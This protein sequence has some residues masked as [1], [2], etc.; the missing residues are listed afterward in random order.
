MIMKIN[1]LENFTL[2]SQALAEA[3]GQWL[4]T[5]DVAAV[6]RKWRWQAGTQ[7]RMTLGEAIRVLQGEAGEGK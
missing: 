4:R 2:G 6:A 5:V 7:K 3:A 1:D